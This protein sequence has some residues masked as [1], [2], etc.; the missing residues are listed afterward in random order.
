MEQL[1]IRD[2]FAA[3][4]TLA[5]L[6]GIFLL[7][8]HLFAP[9]LCAELFALGHRIFAESPTLSQVSERLSAWFA[10]WSA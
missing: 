4:E 10:A 6:T 9:D 3:Q 8:L 2:V 1:S 7:S 5:L